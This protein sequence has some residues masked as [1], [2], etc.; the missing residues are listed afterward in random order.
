MGTVY[1][2]VQVK[3]TPPAPMTVR[4]CSR[5]GM[6]L[7]VVP[8]HHG[9]LLCL[10]AGDVDV[11]HDSPAMHSTAALMGK[12]FHV[13]LLFRGSGLGL[14]GPQTS[15][16]AAADPLHDV[17]AVTYALQRTLVLEGFVAPA[18]APVEPDVAARPPVATPLTS[19][20]PLCRHQ[21]ERAM[22]R[23]LL[24]VTTLIDTRPLKGVV[25]DV[26]RQLSLAQPHELADMC[27]AKVRPPLAWRLPSW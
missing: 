11:P 2:W 10:L 15:P 7:P 27:L 9:S 14:G 13:V 17:D 4:V 3:M 12:C 21:L 25:V 26:M 23:F 1:P 16:H 6:Q 8:A 22:L 24:Y 5:V 18:S 20:L 19:S